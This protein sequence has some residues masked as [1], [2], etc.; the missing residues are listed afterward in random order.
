MASHQLANINPRQA[1]LK[2][3]GSHYELLFTSLAHVMA[4]QSAVRAWTT[5]SGLTSS[6][7]NDIQSRSTSDEFSHANS[8]LNIQPLSS[9]QTPVARRLPLHQVSYKPSKSDDSTSTGLIV[10]WVAFAFI[11]VGMIAAIIWCQQRARLQEQRERLNA[12]PHIVRP[13]PIESETETVV[14]RRKVPKKIIATFPRYT[15]W[16]SDAVGEVSGV[17]E[18]TAEAGQAEGSGGRRETVRSEGGR[19]EDARSNNSSQGSSTSVKSDSS[20][21][22]RPGFF[23]SISQ[24]ISKK[25]KETKEAALQQQQPRQEQSSNFPEERATAGD[26]ESRERRRDDPSTLAG[27]LDRYKD[28]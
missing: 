14:S 26:A 6:S 20:G 4:T 3:P 9:S 23:S 13:D 15:Y 5:T 16:T 24:R 18:E 11:A 17:E 10:A 19:S 8:T 7:F 2:A 22:N 1:A 25:R 21:Q 27:I 28:D 12:A